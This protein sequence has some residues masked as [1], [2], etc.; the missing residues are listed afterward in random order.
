MLYVGPVDIDVLY[1]PACPNVDRARERLVSALDAAG[2]AATIRETEVSTPEEA[3]R[4]GMHG[5]PTILINGRDPFLR[6]GEDASLSCR[7]FDVGGSVEGAPSMEQLVAV[8]QGTDLW[9]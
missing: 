4:A 2:V 1:V 6:E 5:S 3:A 8:L 7:L 9:P